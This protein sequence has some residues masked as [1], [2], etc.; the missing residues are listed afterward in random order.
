MLLA[1]IAP[2]VVQLLVVGFLFICVLMVLTILI[3]RPQGGGL[4]GAFG[5]G[6]G[7]M[8]AGQ[9]AFGA[10]TGD[11]LTIATISIFVIYLVAA[12]GLVYAARSF[13]TGP[14]QPVMQAAPASAVEDLAVVGDEAAIA[15]TPSDGASEVETPEA[16]PAPENAKDPTPPGEAGAGTI[17]PM[18]EPDPGATDEP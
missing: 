8:G 12:V 2:W 18:T 15:E 16:P 14:Q 10:R 11:A 1:Q 6:G 4:S 17:D 7:G 9:T 3:Q 13:A 5:A